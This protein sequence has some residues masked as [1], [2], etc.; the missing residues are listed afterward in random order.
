MIPY[1]WCYF[2][3]HPVLTVIIAYDY[4]QR[5]LKKRP[6]QWHWADIKLMN[7]ISKERR[8]ST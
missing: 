1:P 8:R 7:I 6:D 2:F 4:R 3:S 5:R